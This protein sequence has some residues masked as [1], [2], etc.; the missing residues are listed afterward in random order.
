MKKIIFLSKRTV[1]K[2]YLIA[3]IITFVSNLQAQTTLLTVGP[4]GALTI[5]SEG[6]L[7]VSGLELKPSINYTINETQVTKE[8]TA[9]SLNGAPAME[10]VYAFDSYIDNFSGTIIYNYDES[11]MNG[12]SHNAS[13]YIY[14]STTMQ[15]TEYLDSDSADF[16]VSSTI[17][18]PIQ[19]S[20]VTVGALNSLS[21][22]DAVSMG[23]RI[24]PNPSSSIINVDYSE[25]LE[26]TLFNLL[27]QQLLRTNSKSINISKLD[28]GSYILSAK[29]SNN[30]INNFKIIKR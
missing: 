6:T 27:G 23:I 4:S 20:Q 16:T 8:L 10:K 25:D 26:L 15:W 30:T 17:D 1:I 19:L 12:L 11:E 22:E 7:N 2:R 29:G 28:Q 18:S 3:L 14:D 21:I 13:L 9:V 24:Y 5:N